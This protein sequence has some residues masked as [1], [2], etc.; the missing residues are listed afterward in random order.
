MFSS[1]R[2]GLSGIFT[3]FAILK[4]YFPKETYNL[5][6]FQLWQKQSIFS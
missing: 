6:I 2:D 3:N 4:L 5:K 1:F